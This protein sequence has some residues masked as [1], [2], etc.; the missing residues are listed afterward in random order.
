MLGPVLIAALIA[1]LWMDNHVDSVAM[2]AWLGAAWGL[3]NEPSPQNF[4]P[5]TVLL[6]LGMIVAPLGAR[7]LARMFRTGGVPVKD[8]WLALAAIAGIV[9]FA[10][11]PRDAPAVPSAALVATI[12]TGVMVGSILM[13]LRHRQTHGATAVAGATL[14]SFIYLGL[15]F[16]FVLALR[17]E[18]SAWVVLGVLVVT[19]SCD[20][21]AFF[22]GKAI[23]K[24]KLIPW[25]S[26]G[27]TWE[28]LFGGI[29]L[30]ALVAVGLRALA[31]QALAPDDPVVSMTAW[32]AALTGVAFAIT[33]QAG[34]LLASVLKR[35]AGIKDS[36][37]A[38]PGFGGVLDVADSV[39]LVAPVA[40]WLLGQ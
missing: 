11:V 30:A 1:V 34:D 28:G 22:T 35:D 13:H 19:K 23:G 40:Y 4:P 14:F 5:G 20:I 29:A 25:L 32:Y 21:G 31:E 15:M 17:R 3:L 27:K 12:A 6:V 36:G 2:P 26:P 39:L 18:V 38:L 33:G 10:L 7:E 24:H 16:G 9:T 37:R 8:W